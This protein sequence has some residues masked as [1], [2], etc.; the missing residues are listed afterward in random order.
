[1]ALGS[2]RTEAH[3][4]WF[5]RNGWLAPSILSKT[6]TRFVHFYEKFRLDVFF[7]GFLPFLDLP[8]VEFWLCYP[9]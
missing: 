4:V 7:A 8:W 2:K 1:M 5:L 6:Y 9:G 3:L